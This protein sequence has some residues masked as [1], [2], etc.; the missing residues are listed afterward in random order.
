MRY[1]VKIK[2]IIHYNTALTTKMSPCEMYL[3]TFGYS[4][5]ILHLTSFTIAYAKQPTVLTTHGL[6]SGKTFKTLLRQ[7]EYHGFM[8]IPYAAPPTGDS[9]FLVRNYTYLLEIFKIHKRSAVVVM[10]LVA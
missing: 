5:L 6:V 4:I 7:T 3:K 9:R 1:H 2:S 8:G 10:V